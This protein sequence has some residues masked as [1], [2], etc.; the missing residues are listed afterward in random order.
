MN[1]HIYSN[2]QHK[3]EGALNK[4]E[5]LNASEGQILP[6]TNTLVHE[7]SQITEL[8]AATKGESSNAMDLEKVI[9]AN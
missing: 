7:M 4:L 2:V 5:E 9:F 3:E 8:E 6:C 1:E